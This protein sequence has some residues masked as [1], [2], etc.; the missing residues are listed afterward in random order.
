[1]AADCYGIAFELLNDL[2][3]LERV[4]VTAA[5]YCGAEV[6]SV[7]HKHFSPN[8][9]TILVLLSESHI[10]IHTYPEKGFA[11]VDCYT[12]GFNAD[13]AL[14]IDKVLSDLRPT[15]RYVKGWYRGRNTDIKQFDY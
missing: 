2:V 4:L 1:M 5:E 3:F 7:Q 11:A 10:S 9:V 12:C 15:K 14:A 6:I 13:P 8:G